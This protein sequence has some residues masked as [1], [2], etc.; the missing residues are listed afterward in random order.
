[1]KQEYYDVVTES[2]I[3]A[4]I[5]SDEGLKNCIANSNLQVAFVIYGTVQSIGDIVGELKKAGKTA[6][7][8]VDLIEGLEPKEVAVDFIR[9]Y[10][11]ADGIISSKAPLIKR[12]TELDM[13]TVLRL[14][15]IDSKAYANIE[16]N[17]MKIRPDFL[18]ILPGLMPKLIRR[19]KN[20]FSLPL[21][22]SGMISEKEDVL[23]ALDAGAIAI[24]T[25]NEKV[26]E[27]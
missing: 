8:H 7:V 11:Q 23:T 25:T 2:P 10:T 24:S 14:F 12:A 4:A 1:M 22:A 13:L 6:L 27:M 16:R 18:E 5:K 21:I 15:M 20:E 9:K 26:W 19:I 3:I 17:L